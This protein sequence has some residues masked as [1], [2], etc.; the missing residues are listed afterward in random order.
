MVV[1]VVKVELVM[2]VVVLMDV[3]VEVELVVLVVDVM[4]VVVDMVTWI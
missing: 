1:D 3:V 2:L 4:D